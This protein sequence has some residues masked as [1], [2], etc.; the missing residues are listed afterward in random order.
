MSFQFGFDL[1]GW[2]DDDGNRHGRFTFTPSYVDELLP[3][4]KTILSLFDTTGEWSRPYREAG[5]NVAHI[6][7]QNIVAADVMKL[8]GNG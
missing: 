4:Q 8:T 5:Y 7:I 6:D 1:E 3:G 2:L